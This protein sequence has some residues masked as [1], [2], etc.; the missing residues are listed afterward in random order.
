MSE[1]CMETTLTCPCPAFWA[2]AQRHTTDAH[3]PTR[4]VTS[5]QSKQQQQ[6]QQQVQQTTATEEQPPDEGQHR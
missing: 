2:V 3:Q 4:N 5:R 6:Q 1:S